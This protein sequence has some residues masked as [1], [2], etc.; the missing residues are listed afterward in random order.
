M[1]LGF[2]PRV[3]LV[4]G[5][6]RGLGLSCAKAFV[7]QGDRVAI[8]Y[9][10]DIP[11]E[12]QQAGILAVRCDVTDT[13]QIDASFAEIEETIG[14]IEVLVANAGIHRDVR[15]QKMSDDA[16][17]DVLDTN[18]TGAFRV[19]RRATKKMMSS[20]WGRIVF[21]SSIVGRIGATGAANYSASKSGLVGL[22]RSL[23]HELGRWNITVNVVAPGP[24]R[25]GMGAAL[26]DEIRE[27]Y[28]EAIPLGRLGDPDE[29]AQVVR[30]LAS[31]HASYMTGAVIPVDGGL[32][33]G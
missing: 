23:A 13:E 1:T 5:G 10:T 16:F 20:R 33:M 9:R 22:S 17:I 18:L 21:V 19:A 29:V 12:V 11:S 14:P 30:F 24:L 32:F 15:A 6:N 3:V 4:T 2:V 7:E 25:T 31:E 27:A 28:R 26:P 8:T